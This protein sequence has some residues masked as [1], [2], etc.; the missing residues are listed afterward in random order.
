MIANGSVVNVKAVPYDWD[1]AGKSGVS[2]DLAAVQIVDFIEWTGS[3]VE[4]FDVVEGGYVNTE[5]EEI[6]FAS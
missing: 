1:Y 5:A 2:A 3:Q 6:A 4:D